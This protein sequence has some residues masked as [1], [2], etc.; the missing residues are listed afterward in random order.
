MKPYAEWEQG[1]LYCGDC[2]EILPTLAPGSVDAVVTDPPFGVREDAWDDMNEQEFCRFS[3]QW[4]SQTRRL[5]PNLVAFFASG[6]PFL[7]LCEF[8]YP[9]VRQLIWN[10]PLGSQ[11][12][13]SSDCRM[14]YAYEPIAQC[15]QPEKW[16]VVE[17][18]NLEVAGM[19]REARERK[20]LSRGGVDMLI[21]G[22][23]TG[24]CYRWE[25]AACIPTEQQARILCDVLGMNGEFHAALSRAYSSRDIVL[26]K[27]AEKAAEKCDVFEYRTITGAEHPCE[28]PVGLLADLIECTTEES[29]T[30]LDSFVGVGTTAVACI[31]TGRR[32]IGIELEPK[33]CAIAKSRIDR[34]LAQ[35]KLPFIEPI[36]EKQVEMF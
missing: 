32:F 34:E 24:L 14:W 6:M 18:K 19:I 5:T 30:V 25:E 33:Y 10:K 16:E 3:M 36:R 31:R 29:Q 21:R 27:A 13:G 11:Y 12:A 17:P 1:V 28:K 22:K 9:R 2:L 20:G 15:W 7:R 8:I 35:P 23:K 26:E 4:L